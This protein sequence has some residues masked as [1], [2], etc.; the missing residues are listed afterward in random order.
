MTITVSSPFKPRAVTGSGG[1]AR[2]VMTFV[3]AMSLAACA[4]APST[5]EAASSGTQAHASTPVTEAARMY[6]SGDYAGALYAF[7]KLSKNQA[8]SANDR[9]LANLGKALVYL[10]S[11]P[12]LHSV[13]NAKMALVSATQV[14]AADNEEFLIETNMLME[15]ISFVIG[16]ESKYDVVK[17]KSGDSNAQVSRLKKENAALQSERDALLAEQK[18]LKEALEKL[19]KLTLGN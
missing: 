9:R 1:I 16:T 10:G 19:K 12:E 14:N 8:A 15:A 2:F 18:S 11:D 13:P 17:E 5:P 3:M 7:D 4:T 6:N